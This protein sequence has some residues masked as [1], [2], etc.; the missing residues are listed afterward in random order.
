M[1]E[2][3]RSVLGPH[4]WEHPKHTS[5]AET[6]IPCVWVS[7]CDVCTDE[8]FGI[9]ARCC[10]FPEELLPLLFGHVFIVK[11]SGVVPM[12]N[13]DPHPESSS[14]CDIT[15]CSCVSSDAPAPPRAQ[16]QSH[17]LVSLPFQGAPL[18]RQGGVGWGGG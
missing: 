14:H 16:A 9:S 17:G 12:L 8:R 7:H 5:V 18:C 4:C 15:I 10:S 1:D 3:E 11:N 2:S 13:K 6:F